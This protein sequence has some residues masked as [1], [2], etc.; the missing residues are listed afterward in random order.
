M[1]LLYTEKLITKFL[2]LE[3]ENDLFEC[4][5]NN[6]K[7]WEYIRYKIYG[8]IAKQKLYSAD[9]SH[10]IWDKSL[11][12]KFKVAFDLLYNSI[13]NNP[14]G[15]RPSDI[16]VIN[17]QRRI[18]ENKFFV[19]QYTDDILKN[20]NFSSAVLEYDFKGRHFKPYVTENIAYADTFELKKLFYKKIVA[21]KEV[22]IPT[23]ILELFEKE[24]N[25][26]FNKKFIRK[27]FVDLYVE[28][29]F[30]AKYYT[31][32]LNKVKPKCILEVCY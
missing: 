27:L 6:I 24:F 10:T 16:L 20:I 3:S 5:T 19:D 7:Y 17:H 14:Y 25:I 28:H 13:S 12:D 22:V 32:L 18:K 9:T 21:K 30:M 26:K 8:E 1:K 4:Y 2:K 23:D 31:D 29:N 15:L 11:K